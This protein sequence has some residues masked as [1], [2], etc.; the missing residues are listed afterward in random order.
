[1]KYELAFVP[2]GGGETDYSVT[3]ENA[4]YVPR[5]GEYVVLTDKDETGIRAFRVLYVTAGATL[6]SSGHYREEA[7]VVQAEFVTHPYQSDAHR[8]S[9]EMYAAR[10]KRADDYPT[11][12][13]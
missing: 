4:T 13:Y 3:I 2:P 7:P 6:T 10:G 1:M 9:I 5:V 8:Q 12:G 11:S